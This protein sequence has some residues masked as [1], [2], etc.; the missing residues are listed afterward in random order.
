MTR[1]EPDIEIRLEEA[2]V[3]ITDVRSDMWYIDGRITE[4]PQDLRSRLEQLPLKQNFERPEDGLD[5]K[6]REVTNSTTWAHGVI[7]GVTDGILFFRMVDESNLKAARAVKYPIVCGKCG[8][9]LNGR[10]AECIYC[11]WSIRDSIRKP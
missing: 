9:T 7:L 11:G 2:S 3:R 5:C 6:W 1:K 8:R 10:A 4:C